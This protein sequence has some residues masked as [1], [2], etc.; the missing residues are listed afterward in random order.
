M[1]YKKDITN[2]V[3]DYLNQPPIM[4]LTTV[5]N[6]YVHDNSSWPLLYKN[7]LEFGH[8]YKTLLEG[9]QV[10]KFHLQ[11]A[12]LCHLGHLCVSSSEHAKII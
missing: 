3:V 5:L 9:T 8:T 4:A 7:D 6:S 1:K 2:N 11:D 12:L 10:P